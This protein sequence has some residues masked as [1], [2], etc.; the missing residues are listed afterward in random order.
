MLTSHHQIDKCINRAILLFTGERKGI[1]EE[2]QG[3]E[4][5]EKEEEKEKEQEFRFRFGI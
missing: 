3:K 2:T 5:Q 1:E 4:K